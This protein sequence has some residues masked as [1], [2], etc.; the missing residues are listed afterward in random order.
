MKRQ[1]AS[2]QNVVSVHWADPVMTLGSHRGSFLLWEAV[3][4]KTRTSFCEIMWNSA[5]SGLMQTGHQFVL[6]RSESK[7]FI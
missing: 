3:R 2:F 7:A 5:S 6:V 1:R 4:M